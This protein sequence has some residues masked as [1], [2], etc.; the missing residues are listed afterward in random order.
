ME[1]ALHSQ[2]IGQEEVITAVSDSIRSSRAG[3]ADPQRPNGCFL[4]LGPTVVGKRN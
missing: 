1:T 3:L 2:P 4:F